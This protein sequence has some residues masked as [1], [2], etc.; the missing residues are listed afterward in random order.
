MLRLLSVVLAI[1]ATPFVFAQHM[2]VG[3]KLGVNTGKTELKDLSNYEVYEISKNL[4]HG[5]VYVTVKPWVSGWF[6]QSE[7]LV[8]AR[9]LESELVQANNMLTLTGRGIYGDVPVLIGYRFGKL[10]RVY[11]GPN[12]QLLLNQSTKL[13]ENS[14]ISINEL[15]EKSVGASLGVGLDI[16]D[17][18]FDLRYVYAGNLGSLFTMPDN[19]KPTVV[20]G[21]FTIQLG[22]MLKDLF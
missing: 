1:F 6:L 18:R 12:F 16:F 4:I 13:P 20:N 10:A 5:G 19:A 22:V 3:I 15:K 14:G 11:A 9:D 8:M 21:M 17:F 7:F 2:E